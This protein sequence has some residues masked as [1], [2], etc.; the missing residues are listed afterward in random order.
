MMQAPENKTDIVIIGA[1]LAGLSSALLLAE[2][3]KTVRVVE[4]RAKPGGRI[5]SVFD[6]DS[7]HYIADLGPTWIWPAYQPTV[8]RWLQKL[9]LETY[10]QFETGNAVLDHGPGHEPEI[11]FL[12]GQDGSFRPVGGSQALIDRLV[13]RLPGSVI[14]TGNRVQSVSSTPDRL[15][16]GIAGDKPSYM[17]CETLIVA[18]PPRIA[19]HTIQWDPALPPDLA[20]ALGMTPTWMAPHAKTVVLYDRPFWRDTGLSGRIASRAGPIVE[21]HD[22][23]G[24]DGSPAAL[25]GFI[26]W[27]HDARAEAGPDLESQIRAQLRRCFGADSPEPKS[28]VIEDWAADPLVTSPG[29]LTGP[30][31][32]PQTGPGVLR[33]PHGQDRIWFAGSE[34]ARQSPGLIEGA[35][36]AAEQVVSRLLSL[37]RVG[38]DRF[39]GRSTPS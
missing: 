15:G 36:D 2:A 16:I 17:A 31:S 14:L 29:D 23:C 28:I 27:P 33:Q 37:N 30:M 22:H 25:F 3:G 39:T 7:G 34:T 24:P 20:R 19:L 26:G 35:F 38:E 12:P 8:A 32:H 5:R 13:A 6:K 1:G 4:A 10:S 18:V 11:R 9:G 21:A